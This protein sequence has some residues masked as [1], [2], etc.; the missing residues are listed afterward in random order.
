MSEIS[1]AILCIG[2]E[3]L[4]TGKQD[5]NGPW[6]SHELNLLGYTVVF[7]GV[8]ADSR[9][10]ITAQLQAIDADLVIITGGLGGTRDDITVNCLADFLNA[11]T[12]LDT[13]AM[14]R[15]ESLLIKRYPD[16]PERVQKHISRHPGFHK[17]QQ[18]SCLPGISGIA[19]GQVVLADRE[20]CKAADLSGETFHRAV[21][22]WK[23][24]VERM[25]VLLPGVP[26][27][28]QPLFES[29]APLLPGSE[30][31]TF[32]TR[33]WLE[34]ET[35]FETRFFRNFSLPQGCEYGVSFSTGSL[36]L[37]FRGHPHD[38]NTIKK[39]LHTLY[40]EHRFCDNLAAD[41]VALGSQLGIT[42]ASVESCT[43]GWIAMEITSVPGSSAVLDGAFVTYS[44]QQKARLGVQETTLEKYGAVS[45]QTVEQMVQAGL[46]HS[47]ASLCVATSGIAGP[48]G[49][50]KDKP[51]GTVWT[52]WGF[53]QGVTVRTFTSLIHY[54]S[55][56][57][58]IRQYT[59][60][61]CLYQMRNLLLQLKSGKQA[62][63]L[64]QDQ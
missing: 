4:Q 9:Q 59:V 42:M 46:D 55:S 24:G 26:S 56:R 15:L 25:Y 54:P 58:K 28:N 2:S 34:N 27:E 19:S 1:A 10:S 21:E 13:T 35:G 5:T 31:S 40:G 61:Y 57:E 50:T 63:Q 64:T 30:L 37:F 33:L 16:R 43:G 47:D 44:N 20:N 3:L 7:T 6:L 62:G 17:I 23:V 52:A 45:R 53:R 60:N 41:V 48:D 11:D 22:N 39:R 18:A 49:G 51:V 14:D 8:V 12:A 29:M 36:L 32:Q 38:L